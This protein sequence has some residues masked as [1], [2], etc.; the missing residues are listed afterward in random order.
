[1]I[2][3]PTSGRTP[4][5]STHLEFGFR[6]PERPRSA[7][8]VLLGVVVTL[9]AGIGLAPTISQPAQPVADRTVYIFQPVFPGMGPWVKP[10]RIPLNNH[11]QLVNVRWR[12]WGESVA[13][14]SG[15]RTDLI[16]APSCAESRTVRYYRVSVTASE[17]R[18]C[19]IIVYR[20]GRNRSLTVWLY[21]RVRFRY[22]RMRPSGFPPTETLPRPCSSP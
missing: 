21:D 14:A 19:T 15:V 5:I 17:A 11:E 20:G 13:R 3:R 8:T 18:R 6:R 10:R 22:V 7:R 1:M 2:R 12:S 16:C 4:Q 9:G